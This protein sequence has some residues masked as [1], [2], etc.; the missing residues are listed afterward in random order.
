MTRPRPAIV[1][2][3]FLAVPGPLVAQG[4]PLGPEFRVNTYTT[5]AQSHPSVASDSAGNFVVVWQ[6]S[7]NQDSN[8][9]VFGQRY[10]AIRPVELQSFRVE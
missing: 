5:R 10:S 9:G 8:A 2:L 7:G 4:E 3:G 6:G 1:L